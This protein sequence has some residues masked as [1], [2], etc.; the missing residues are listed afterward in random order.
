MSFAEWELVLSAGK[1]EDADKVWTEIKGKPLQMV[2]NVISATSEKLELAG[3]SDDIDAK[4]ADIELTMTGPIPAKLMPKVDESLPFQ[5]T[6][7]SYTASPFVMQ[8]EQ[9][10]LLTQAKPKAPVHHHPATAQ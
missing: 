1:P 5:G 6:P 3:S 8:M 10:A 9:G 7:A 4:K 2:A